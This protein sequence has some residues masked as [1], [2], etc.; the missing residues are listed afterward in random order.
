MLSTTYVGLLDSPREDEK[1]EMFLSDGGDGEVRIQVRT[2]ARSGLGWYPQKT[3]TI[4]PTQLAAL[5]VL[6]KRAR[7]IVAQ[8]SAPAAEPAPE[9]QVIRLPFLGCPAVAD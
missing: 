2:I 9:S 3:I 5:E 8:R 7:A 1:I 6:V 4:H